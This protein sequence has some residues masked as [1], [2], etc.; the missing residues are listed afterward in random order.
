MV[1]FQINREGQKE[2]W[3]IS[4]FTQIKM[5]TTRENK[6]QR[7]GQGSHVRERR[8]AVE[9]PGKPSVPPLLRCAFCFEIRT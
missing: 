3:E 9:K 4:F 6:A 7:A 8:L 1:K 2:G 5:I